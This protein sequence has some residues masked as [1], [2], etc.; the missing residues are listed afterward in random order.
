MEQDNTPPTT[1]CAPT[2]ANEEQ[3]AMQ[4][5]LDHRNDD[6]DAP[7]GHQTREQIPDESGR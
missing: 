3:R 7:G 5:K 1:S 4:D 2:D 6:P